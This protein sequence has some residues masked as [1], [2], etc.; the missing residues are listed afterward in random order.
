MLPWSGV[1][2]AQLLRAAWPPLQSIPHEQLRPRR[3]ERPRRR[4]S[5]R[6]V[7]RPPSCS[8]A[9]PLERL[10]RR[11]RRTVDVTPLLL[12]RHRSPAASVPGCH[13]RRARRLVDQA[14]G[15][16]S[17]RRTHSGARARS[18]GGGP[19]GARRRSRRRDSRNRTRV[20]V[21]D[22]LDV[23]LACGADGVHLRHDSMPAA[24]C[25]PSR[26]RVSGRPIG[27]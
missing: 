5:V 16:S 7:R 18:R 19:G 13:L 27:A 3:G 17:R 22:R 15:P 26:R 14:R 4:E 24:A 9:R 21:N 2:G 6:R 20:V 12:P 1:L 25:A 10:A 23:A 11:R 8:R